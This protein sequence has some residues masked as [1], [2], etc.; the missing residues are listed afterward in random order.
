MGILMMQ[1]A[2]VARQQERKP[3]AAG[4]LGFTG[5]L[6]TES[7]LG[8]A[9]YG[10]QQS[11]LRNMESVLHAISS[12]Q[13][14][15]LDAWAQ[16][17][18]DTA[19][20]VPFPNTLTVFSRASRQWKPEVRGDS[21]DQRL[22]NIVK[23]RLDFAMPGQANLPLR[24]GLWGEPLPETPEGALPYLHQFLDVTRGRTVPDDPLNI[25]LYTLWRRTADA[26]VIPTPPDRSITI[27]QETYPLN[28]EQHSRLQELVGKARRDIAA[29][30]VVSPDFLQL[31]AQEKI[32]ELK[33]IWREGSQEGTAEFVD[34]REAELQRKP[35][36]SGLP[37]RP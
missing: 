2:H 32:A 21:F 36:P 34:E 8:A 13:D 33:D 23:N 28:R 11:F 17:F 3:E 29:E 14:N 15:A 12:G 7:S 10:L 1:A 19:M 22:N 35:K 30:V 16:S 6:L 4:A 31:T 24:R 26:A 18:S 27:D 20:S 9:Q 5:D 25:T 37:L